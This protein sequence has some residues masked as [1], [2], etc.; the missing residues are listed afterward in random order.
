MNQIK[1]YV[2]NFFMCQ[3]PAGQ[4]WCHK[5]GGGF[6]CF[7]RCKD[8]GKEWN[9]SSKTCVARCSS[10]LVWNG[11]RCVRKCDGTGE[12]GKGRDHDSSACRSCVTIPAE[13][14]VNWI[15]A[16][17]NRGQIAGDC[18]PQNTNDPPPPD[19]I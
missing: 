5:S 18:I 3:C 4:K 7:E 9:S 6:D 10:G 17:S 11:K 14:G 19:H 2:Q 8:W 16:G 13:D 12:N 15:V 1:K